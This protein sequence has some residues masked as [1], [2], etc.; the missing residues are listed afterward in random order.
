[1]ESD[2]REEAMKRKKMRRWNDEWYRAEHEGMFGRWAEKWAKDC[3][4]WFSGQIRVERLLEEDPEPGE[5]K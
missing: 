5:E 3:K 4:K 2:G 1:M